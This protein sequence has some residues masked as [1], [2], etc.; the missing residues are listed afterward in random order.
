MDFPD[1]I[2]SVCIISFCI[3]LISDKELKRVRKDIVDKVSKDVIKQLLDGLLDDGVLNDGEKDSVL[4][5]N[6]SRADR[7]CC[8]IDIVK[9]KG[10]Q[11][12]RKMIAQLQSIDPILHSELAFNNKEKTYSLFIC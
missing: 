6:V 7:A 5:E 1:L 10:D 4:E 12:S 9:K 2:V 11:A 3:F 8:L